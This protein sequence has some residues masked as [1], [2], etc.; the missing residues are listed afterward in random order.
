[1]QRIIA[2][3]LTK[4]SYN[5][6]YLGL[7]V[8][9]KT[10]K[11]PFSEIFMIHRFSQKCKIISFRFDLSEIIDDGLCS[12]G[13]SFDLKFQLSDMATRCI[14]EGRGESGPDFFG[15]ISAGDH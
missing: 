2:S 11:D 13:T 6:V 7:V 9:T 4:R 14:T 15:R 12:L 10:C 5:S 8:F 1:M 3:L